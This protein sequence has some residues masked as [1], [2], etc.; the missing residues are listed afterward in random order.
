MASGVLASS[1][2]R[3]KVGLVAVLR[4]CGAP[5]DCDS[6]RGVL[7]ALFEKLPVVLQ[8][9]KLEDLLYEQDMC[10]VSVLAETTEEELRGLGL[11]VGAAR[12]VCKI[13]FEEEVVEADPEPLLVVGA[14]VPQVGAHAASRGPRAVLR[15]FPGLEATGYPGVRGW[16]AYVP[17]LKAFVAVA[18]GAGH[19]GPLL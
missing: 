12:L 18:D 6:V 1:G 16:K 14:E 9:Q 5:D 8:E 17:A 2:V 7:G 13:I 15:T 3:R 10:F 4:E 11:S 19:E